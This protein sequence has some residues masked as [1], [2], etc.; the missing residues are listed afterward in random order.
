MRRGRRAESA[1]VAW[2]SR[3]GYDIL[4]R[5]LRVGRNEIDVVARSGAIIVVVEVRHRGVGAWQGP[6]ESIDAAK[7]ERL[8][9]AATR[10][11]NERFESDPSVERLRFDVA[12][13]DFGPTGEPV[14][15]YV[16]GVDW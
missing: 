7:R 13:V 10:L 8:R 1:V 2:L 3:H 16:Q 6:F 15:E 14:V 4:D 12:A 5:N 11:W 9:T